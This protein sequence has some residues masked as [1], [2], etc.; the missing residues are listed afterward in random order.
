M[1][2]GSVAL[3]SYLYPQKQLLLP[4]LLTR[5]ILF[6]FVATTM[7]CG[8][9]SGLTGELLYL[10]GAIAA[11]ILLWMCFVPFA[12]R[13]PYLYFTLRRKLIR[14]ST[15]P[16]FLSWQWAASRKLVFY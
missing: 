5:F 14:R 8:V 15:K 10:Y 2:E 3:I 1:N 6:S 4:R 12:Y 16:G 11:H 7:V 9:H 13:D